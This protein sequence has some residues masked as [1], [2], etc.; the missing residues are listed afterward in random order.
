M[1]KD[2]LDPDR[3]RRQGRLAGD[4]HVRHPE[5]AHQRLPVPRRP[6]GA[7]RSP[8][9]TP[10]SRRSSTPGRA[11]CPAPGRARSAA[12]G[13]RPRRR[14]SRRRPACTCSALFVAQQFTTTSRRTSTSSP[15]RRSTPTIGAGLDRRPDRRLHDGRQAQERGAARRRCSAT[16][17]SAEAEHIW[18]RPTRPTCWPT[19]APTPAATPPAEEVGRAHRLG[20]EHRP[21]PRPGHPA[22]L[23]FDR[24]DPGAAAVHQEPERHRRAHE[25]HRDQA[26]SIFV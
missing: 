3:L 18:A 21:V 5:H 24:D 7:A 10:R 4:G 6:D 26:K 1:K 11:C 25:Q 9:P 2:G 15:S 23:R 12:P 17:A 19:A 20:Q 22:G 8:G 13:R 16:S 14:C